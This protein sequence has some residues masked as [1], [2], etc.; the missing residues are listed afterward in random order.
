M[1]S[2][3]LIKAQEHRRCFSNIKNQSKS[4]RKLNNKRK[5]GENIEFSPFFRLFVIAGIHFQLFKI[6]CFVATIPPSKPHGFATSLCTREANGFTDSLSLLCVKG[7]GF[8]TKSKNRRDCIIHTFTPP[9][10]VITFPYSPF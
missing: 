4:S 3:V 7:G 1:K 6:V 2:A 10:G 9:M 5:N 8:W